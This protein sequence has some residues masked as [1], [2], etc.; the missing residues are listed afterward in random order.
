MTLSFDDERDLL[1]FFAL[2]YFEKSTM[3]PQMER[4]ELFHTRVGADGVSL[5]PAPRARVP[6]RESDPMAGLGWAEYNEN[7]QAIT[8]HPTGGVVIEAKGEPND[9]HF[10]LI[11]RVSRKIAMLSKRNRKVLEHLYGDRGATC[12]EREAAKDP[13]S[14]AHGRIV[15]LY[16][17]TPAGRDI[18]KAERA[19]QGSVS[20]KLTRAA[21]IMAAVDGKHGDRMLVSDVH[22]Q[23]L[24]LQRVAEAAYTEATYACQEARAKAAPIVKQEPLRDEDL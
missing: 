16:E 3:G 5:V 1:G 13:K 9:A 12:A 2:G 17:L 23:A 10:R 21:L 22:Q 8:A 6:D 19:V 4:A 14:G 7:G 15:A 24:E 18:A 20:K 11:G